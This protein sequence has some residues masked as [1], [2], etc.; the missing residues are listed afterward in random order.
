MY[1]FILSRHARM[2]NLITCAGVTCSTQSVKDKSS[3]TY[4]NKLTI[5][6]ATTDDAGKYICLGAN[7][8]G[9]ATKEAYL[10]VLDGVFPQNTDGSRQ[11]YTILNHLCVSWVRLLVNG[12]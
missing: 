7:D 3:G 12:R 4:T 6:R 1:I 9:F 2:L 10:T 5:Q 11:S 8:V